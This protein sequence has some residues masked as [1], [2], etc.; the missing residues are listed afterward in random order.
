MWQKQIV[1]FNLT[2][3]KKSD[4]RELLCWRHNHVHRLKIHQSNMFHIISSILDKLKKKKLFTTNFILFIIGPPDLSS[5]SQKYLIKNNGIRTEQVKS[6]S[7]S[8]FCHK[9]IFV[10]FSNLE[11]HDHYS[12]YT[13]NMPQKFPIFLCRILSN[14]E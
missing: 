11:I 3:L 7:I 1:K 10:R 6:L 12:S 13:S 4:D 9:L 5:Q 8:N 2:R 14:L